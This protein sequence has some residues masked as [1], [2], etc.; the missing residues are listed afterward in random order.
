LIP[1]TFSLHIWQ[2]N[3]WPYQHARWMEARANAADKE[4]DR[5]EQGNFEFTTSASVPRYFCNENSQKL[6]IVG[7]KPQEQFF[8]N[9]IKYSDTQSAIDSLNLHAAFLDI[10]D[11]PDNSIFSSE[12][13]MRS[14]NSPPAL[15][16]A[17]VFRRNLLLYGS[18]TTSSSMCGESPSLDEMPRCLEEMLPMLDRMDTQEWS[19][20]QLQMG[21]TECDLAYLVC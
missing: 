9:A 7:T 5:N 1:L 2:I 12:A 18:R 8:S 19:A 10:D 11:L 15:K 16:T 4:S 6:Q 20:E 3:R 21:Y 14:C 17:S 13:L